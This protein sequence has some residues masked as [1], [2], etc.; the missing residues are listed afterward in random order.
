MTTAADVFGM[1]GDVGVTVAAVF[2]AV[3]SIKLRR[4]ERRARAHGRALRALIADRIG[5]DN[6]TPLSTILRDEEL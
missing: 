5:G 4:L 3:S 6:E 1:V 2:I